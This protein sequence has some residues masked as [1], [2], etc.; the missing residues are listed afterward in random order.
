MGKRCR[1]QSGFREWT[2][3]EKM[4]YLDWDKAEDDRVTREVDREIRAQ[5]YSSRRGTREIWRAAE[6][7]DEEQQALFLA[8]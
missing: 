5:P 3:E 8:R 1:L 6:K 2:E 7:D 4:A